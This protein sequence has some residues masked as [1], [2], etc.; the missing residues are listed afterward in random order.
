MGVLPAGARWRAAIGQASVWPGDV[1]CGIPLREGIKLY[2]AAW[3]AAEAERERGCVDKRS[4]GRPG[5]AQIGSRKEKRRIN[6]ESLDASPALRYGPI[7]AGRDT[8]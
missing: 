2:G 7:I 8:E 4:C 6:T 1:G 3:L 5:D